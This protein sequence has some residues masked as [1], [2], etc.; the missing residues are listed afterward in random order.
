M[1]PRDHSRR[2]RRVLVFSASGV[3]LL[4][5]A[6]V[7]ALAV[8]S[9][10]GNGSAGPGKKKGDKD[11]VSAAPVQISRVG[12]DDI[13]TFLE[14]TTTLEPRNS[15]VLVARRQGQVV[16]LPAEEGDWA[17]QGQVLAKIDD[18]EAQLA[19]ARAQLAAEVADKEAKRGQ[20]LKAQS[21]ISDKALDDLELA[22]RTAWQQ[23]E[24]A[25][26]DLSQTR[27]VAPFAGRVVRRMVNLG[28]TVTPGKECF[29]IADTDPLLARVYFPEREMARV[30]V[31]QP[32]L[33]ELDIHPDKEFPARVSLVNPA[34][35]RTNGTFK[36]TLEVK[37]RTGLLRCGSFA[38]VKLRT[39]TFAD[40][41]VISRRALV[42]EDGDDFVFRA[43]AD[44]VDRVKVS[45]GATSGDTVQILAGLTEGDSVV[46]VG[47][48]GLKQGSRIKPVTF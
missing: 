20:Q 14:T 36:V 15:A 26:Y 5:V 28:E 41:L 1:E 45:L 19:L 24:Q 21:L 43:R 42:S 30:Q 23:L 4:A 46:T 6:L 11:A 48:G 3:A 35:D 38:R 7:I 16:A 29:E 18:T 22:R 37:D 47:Q 34:V 27:I 12:R 25:K 39:G 8:K 10:R 17:K 40:A 44:S 33:L 9:A 13:S 31:G 32:A 2:P